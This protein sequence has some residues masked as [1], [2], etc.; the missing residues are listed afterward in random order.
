MA[1]A[2][3][4]GGGGQAGWVDIGFKKPG[5]DRRNEWYVA[6]ATQYLWTDFTICA[7][8]NASTTSCKEYAWKMLWS[9]QLN[10]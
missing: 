8:S 10:L 4:V 1:W 9:G 3:L 6:L 2:C 5:P 7:P